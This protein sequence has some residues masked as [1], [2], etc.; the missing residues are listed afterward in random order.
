MTGTAV[1]AGPIDTARTDGTITVNYLYQENANQP[2]LSIRGVHFDLYHVADVSADG[3]YTA[4]AGFETSATGVDLRLLDNGSA[5]ALT[6]YLGV[7]PQNPVSAGESSAT[8]Q[9]L[10][11]QL[12]PGLYLVVSRVTEMDGYTYEAQPCLVGVPME[13]KTTGEWEYNLTTSPKISRNPVEQLS[14]KTY[15]RVMK[16]W[17]DSDNRAN[18][19]PTSVTVHLVQDNKEDLGQVPLNAANNWT[20]TWD[21]LESNHTWAIY[22]EPVP[23]YS[24]S[25]MIADDGTQILINTYP[26]GNLIN[27]DDP[28]K[29]PTDD[30]NTQKKDQGDTPTDGGDK[31]KP[32]T[33]DNTKG[34]T[35]TPTDT[36]TTKTPTSSKNTGTVNGTTSSGSTTT[37]TTTTK[38]LQTGQLWWPVPVLAAGGLLSIVVGVVRRRED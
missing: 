13:D 4:R 8:G 14:E 17:N 26:P 22:E 3:S 5:A 15:V 30:D 19:R 37:K 35:N 6:A 16:K 21:N 1:A 20:Y 9:S 31:S 24:A 36:S 32:S 25:L 34:K 38:L 23:D 29:N 27:D 28:S 18:R 10:I 12:T 33:D 11:T 2:A 7:H